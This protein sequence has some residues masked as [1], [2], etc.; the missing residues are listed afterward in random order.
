[1]VNLAYRIYNKTGNTL[2]PGSDLGLNG[3]FRTN[4]S[5]ISDPNIV[6]DNSSK[7]FFASL[8]DISNQSVK[9]AVSAPNDP[10][11]STWNVFNFR[12]GQ[13]PDQPFITVS[14][15][16]VAISFNTFTS[17]VANPCVAPFV[18]AQTLLINKDDLVN[19]RPPA[20]HLTA[21]RPKWLPGSPR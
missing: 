11:P 4:A 8:I 6:F 17:P 13:C 20:F 14:S 12:I 2:A 9:V 3:L 5:R 21:D 1:M 18:G 7:R 10:N 19:A 16:K 15:N